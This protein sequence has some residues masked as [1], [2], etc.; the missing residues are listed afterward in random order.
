MKHYRA[1]NL[2]EAICGLEI[3]HDGASVLSIRGDKDDPFSQGHICPK[4]VAL[5]DIY[6]DPDRLKSPVRKTSKGWEKISWRQAFD[7]I[8]QKLAPIR[9]QHGRD[10]V[11]VYLGNPVVHNYGSLIF[12][13]PF[14]RALGTRN[15][16]TATSVDQLPHQFAA[17]FMLGHS[18]LLPIPDIDR[19]RHIL[20]MGANPLASNGSMM[21]A[22]GFERRLRAIR[23]KGGKVILVDPR[24]TETA[25]CADEHHFIA[26]GSDVFL[27]LALLN[28]IFEKG[29][30]RP[31]RLEKF[32]RNLG[33][34]KAAVQGVTPK[35]AE[36]KTGI[37]AAIIERM[38]CEFA[39]S[40]AAVCYGRMGLSTQAHGGLCQWL[41]NAL[42]I[43]T[44]NFDRPGG[45]MFPL[46]AVDLTGGKSTLGKAGR[47]KSRIRGLAEFDGAL[48]AAVMA[49]E[50]L[51]KGK[52]RIRA[53]FTN[54]GNPVLSTPNGKQLEKALG[55]LDLMVSID[56]YIN[57][58]TRHADFILP[59]T[60]G[61]ETDHYDLVFNGLAV[62]NVAKYSPVL[63]KPG[64]GRLADWQ[65]LKELTKR[66]T[67]KKS[68]LASL[69]YKLKTPARILKLGLLL[70]PYGAWKS[71]AKF[72]TGLTLRRLKRRVHGIDLG[73]LQPRLP[74]AL[75]T[76]D[77]K[78]D[79]APPVFLA[80]LKEV[81]ASPGDKG[82]A[83]INEFALIGR[84]HVRSN[85]SWM[86]NTQRLMK[87]KGRCTVMVNPADAKNLRVSD[88]QRV[89]VSSRIGKIVLPAE[90]TDDIM[91]GVVSIPH[92][93]G[94]TGKGL[95]LRV[96]K[97]H[98]GQ[99]INDL[100]D[101]Q[102]VDK[103]TG[104]AAFSAQIVKIRPAPKA[105]K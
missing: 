83:D 48:P 39:A 23:K 27:L 64:P 81:T 62:R 85:N 78:L 6:E 94:H 8:D 105:R 69:K 45:A 18:L 26:P 5:K 29:L 31:G 93:Y 95:E 61:L 86:H 21:T 30:E 88:G 99:S 82:G 52:G 16:F 65:I 42:N 19:C 71:P 67:P 103:L 11:A 28:V 63:F 2:C 43:I 36:A 38:A 73:P 74:G 89:E 9:R 10:S 50:M 68:A 41:I 25:K 79:A 96:A 13:R 33:A 56:I 102:I 34:L 53:L 72:F 58:T 44:G 100:T 51:A 3:E 46:P 97:A 12:S 76:P 22:P 80:R 37:P 98:A 59:P 15:V 24:K 60:T 84:R 92:G 54:S 1:C 91:P 77:K 104:N 40:G 66:L 55:K 75:L 57:E 87:G 101:D 20:I 35:I 32:T 90:L 49:E 14:I 7:Q 17:S 47:W 4:A 70:G